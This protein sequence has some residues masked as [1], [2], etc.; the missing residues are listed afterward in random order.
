M[1]LFAGHDRIVAAANGTTSY[2]DTVYTTSVQY[3]DGLLVPGSN[4][5]NVSSMMYTGMS[6][7]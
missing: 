3:A 4:G 6:N 5:K 7:Q 1:P 2:H